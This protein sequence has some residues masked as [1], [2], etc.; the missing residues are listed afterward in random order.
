MHNVL[1]LGEININN[2]IAQ[3]LLVTFNLILFINVFLVLLLFCF[4]VRAVGHKENGKNLTRLAMD[5][6]WA[7]GGGKGPVCI[8]EISLVGLRCSLG[9]PKVGPTALG[10]T[11]LFVGPTMGLPALQ[12]AF[13]ANAKCKYDMTMVDCVCHHY[14]NAI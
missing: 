2:N 1:H 12:G 4:D 10:L 3:I 6:Y 8:F 14:K 7:V 13:S 5:H 11:L 9:G